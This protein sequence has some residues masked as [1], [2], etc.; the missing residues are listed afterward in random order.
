MKKIINNKRYDTE[1]AKLLGED[2]YSNWGDFHFWE[3]TLYQKR[4]GEFFLHGVGGPAS[5]YAETVGQNQW[6]G[7]EKIIPL[8]FEKAREWAEKHLEADAYEEIFGPVEEDDS[9]RL[10]SL[11]LPTTAVETLKRLAAESGKSQSEI[12]TEMILNS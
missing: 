7:G 4:T 8:K 1:T 12:V 5:K 2:S 6:T 11:S 10:I 3:E 9:R